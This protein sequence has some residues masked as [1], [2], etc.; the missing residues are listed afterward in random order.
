MFWNCPYKFYS[1]SSFLLQ[2]LILLTLYMVIISILKVV[3]YMLFCDYKRYTHGKRF[4]K[5]TLRQS[6]SA[7]NELTLW[8]TFLFHQSFPG[9]WRVS[10]FGPLWLQV[11]YLT[12]AP[13]SYLICQ[14]WLT[15]MEFSVWKSCFTEKQKIVF[16][17]FDVFWTVVNDNRHTLQMGE[18]ISTVLE[19]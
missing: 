12:P 3:A 13:P 18:Y 17:R 10:L 8:D 16:T 4:C 6:L 9:N 19:R 11:Q 1:T 5:K 2:Y 7:Q 14:P 15:I